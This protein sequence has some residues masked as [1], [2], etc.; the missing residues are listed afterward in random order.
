M[1]LNNPIIQYAIAFLM[2]L[3]LIGGHN[4]LLNNGK[5]NSFKRSIIE[6]APQEKIG[7]YLMLFGG[8]VLL[9]LLVMILLKAPFSQFRTLDGLIALGVTSIL[10]FFI[11][12]TLNGLLGIMKEDKLSLKFLV[13]QDFLLTAYLIIFAALSFLNWIKEIK[14]YE[15]SH[16]LIFV[17]LYSILIIA[18]GILLGI[19][20]SN[21]DGR[22]WPANWQFRAIIILDPILVGLLMGIF[23]KI[24]LDIILLIQ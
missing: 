19:P 8:T 13:K 15:H 21:G 3:S 24:T 10:S 9:M 5:P 1:N 16:F 4:W 14:T 11:I 17:V 22:K 12:F 20:K 6:L 7:F 23:V 18:I 2:V